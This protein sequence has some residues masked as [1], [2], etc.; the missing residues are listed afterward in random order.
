MTPAFF[1]CLIPSRNAW[2]TKYAKLKNNTDI[3]FVHPAQLSC[4]SQPTTYCGTIHRRYS[5]NKTIR[6]ITTNSK[7]GNRFYSRQLLEGQHTKCTLILFL[8]G[9]GFFLTIIRFAY[10]WTSVR[11]AARSVEL[12]RVWPFLTLI[13]HPEGPNTS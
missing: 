8:D 13:A 7:S 4:L 6:V 10:L 11:F 9:C 5:I 3:I 2:L 12:A 1:Y